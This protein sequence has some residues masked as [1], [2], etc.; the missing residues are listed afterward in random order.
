MSYD[1]VADYAKRSDDELLLL[2]SHHGSLIHEAATALDAE[3]SRRNLAKSDQVEYQRFVHRTEQREYRSRRPRKLFGVSHFSLLQLFW[4]LLAMGLISFAYL[5][6]P[7]RY[8]LKPD[9]E[10]AAAYV[11][12]PSVVIAVGWWSLRR[13]IAFWIAADPLVCRSIG[14]CAC[15]DTTRT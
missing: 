13:D 2:A 11:M 14:C 3:L 1:F 10:E 8:H 5:A 6:L 4:A 12:I 9:W 15:L 7:N